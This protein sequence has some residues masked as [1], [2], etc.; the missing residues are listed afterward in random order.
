V[1]QY[2]PQYPQPQGQGPIN[3]SNMALGPNPYANPLAAAKRAGVLQIV[4]ASLAMLFGMC[5]GGSL[6]VVTPEMMAQSGQKLPPGFSIEMLRIV[7]AILLGMGA[8][9]A[10]MLILGIFVVKASKGAT[11]ASIIIACLGMAYFIF[12]TIYQLSQGSGGA[13]VDLVLVAIIAWLVVWLFQAVGG[14]NKHRIAQFQYAQYY[15]QQQ[16]QPGAIPTQYPNQPYAQPPAPSQQP[17]T[18][19]QPQWP[20]PNQQNWPPPQA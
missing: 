16:Q 12:E 20:N 9:G 8:L 15:Q 14:I 7:G 1:S 5:A 11:I 3:Y 13:L 17:Q 4:L 6:M 2:P 19:Q 18:F 10:L